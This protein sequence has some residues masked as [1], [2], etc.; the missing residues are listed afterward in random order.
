MDAVDLLNSDE[1]ELPRLETDGSY[2]VRLEAAPSSYTRLAAAVDAPDFASQAVAAAVSRIQELGD[3]LRLVHRAALDGRPE[4]A[5]AEM[6]AALDIVT[7]A[8][9]FTEA[10]RRSELD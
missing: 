2:G 10:Y 5:H 4:R 9:V 3:R 7:S 6:K 8:R 1:T